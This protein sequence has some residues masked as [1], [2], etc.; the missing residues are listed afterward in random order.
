MLPG[1]A[2][3]RRPL[4]LVLFALVC[5]PLALAQNPA[6]ASPQMSIT[7]GHSAVALNGPWK[8][9]IG[10]NPQ[11]ASPSFNDSSWETTDVGVAADSYDPEQGTPGY[12]PGWTGKGHP[13]Y[14]GY[15]WYR[16]RI[17][18]SS[19]N[20]PLSLLAPS[21]VDDSY[22]IF[23]N[24]HLIGSF[25]DFSG[26][27]PTVYITEPRMFRIPASVLQDSPD[28][29]LDIAFRFY[30]APRELLQILPGGMHDP[31]YIGYSSAIEPVYHVKW[32]SQYRE[33]A[34]AAASVLIYLLFTLLILMLY[35]FD[36]TDRILMWPLSACAVSGLDA[37]LV[38][39]V[40]TS[41]LLTALYQVYAGAILISAFRAL[42]AITWWAYFGLQQKKWIRNA[43]ILLTILETAKD[44]L[45]PW[46]T[47]SGPKAPHFIF[48]AYFTGSYILDTV[49]FV[50]LILI[51]Y[52]GIRQAQKIDWMLLLAVIFFGL[53][54]LN[55]VY[56]TL[57]IRTAWFPFGLNLGL[58]TITSLASLFCFSIVLMRR[59][60]ASQRRQQATLED[61]R[62]AQE[63]QQ[64]LIPE[65]LPQV[66]GLTIE[67]E[68]RPAR[69]VGGDFFQIIPH[70]T[71]GSVLIVAGDVVGKGLKAGMLVAV[72]VGGIRGTVEL[73]PDPVH[74]LQALNRRLMGRGDAHATALAMRIAA[75]GS[76]TLANAGHLP[77]YLNGKPVDMEGAL[78]LG[79]VPDFQPSIT[80]FQLSEGDRLLLVSDGIAEAMD[81]EGHLFGFERVEQ[82]LAQQ[83]NA[84][85]LSATALA[86][87]AQKFG[88]EDDISVI[89]ITMQPSL[90]AATA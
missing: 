59:F 40:N 43:V 5:A 45:F 8:F 88:Q 82:M 24:G 34:S 51:V 41:L 56:R 52:F 2:R 42:W 79:F 44:L 47:T 28:G 33:T 37:L 77:P 84:R 4:L 49:A 12:V 14:S 65:E 86:D 15:A 36:R 3:M 22:Q 17:H 18:L 35:A 83:P 16:I 69:E 46:L 32:E 78:P 80:K 53:P 20:E 61:V 23:I 13:G 9:H 85:P 26:S 10:D 1:K 75:D 55:P 60:R 72:L 19:A 66:P 73:N 25:G 90:A 11:W 67:S 63:V 89:T 27:L 50:L 74:M 29:N 7:L 62:Q 71:D 57:H 64:V 54:T 38:C 48:T 81:A 68:Y 30:M 21:D 39:F 31:P 6:A 87:A 76:V 70:P 58:A